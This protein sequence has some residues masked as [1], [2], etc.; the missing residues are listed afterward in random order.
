MARGQENM[1]GGEDEDEEGRGADAQPSKKQP[2]LGRAE[3]L[4]VVLGSFAG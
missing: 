1:L 3:G 2:G 4:Q